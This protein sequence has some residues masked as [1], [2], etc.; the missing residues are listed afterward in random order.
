[1]QG[2]RD[3][4]VH[5]TS[6]PVPEGS[7]V[8]SGLWEPCPP[9]P[10]A[11]PPS[12]VPRPPR[13]CRH[14]QAWSG[15]PSAARERHCQ[16]GRRGGG[17]AATPEPLAPLSAAQLPQQGRQQG[18]IPP[19]LHLESLD[20]TCRAPPSPPFPTEDAV[21]SPPARVLLHAGCST[22]LWSGSFPSRGRRRNVFV[23][24]SFSSKAL[25]KQRLP[26]ERCF[27][28]CLGSWVWLLRT[29]PSAFCL[30]GSFPCT[31]LPPDSPAVLVSFWSFLRGSRASIQAYPSRFMHPVLANWLQQSWQW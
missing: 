9:S 13:P 29:F 31:P 24:P 22:L 8:C 28:A 7:G 27:A 16:S 15:A 5:T 4:R 17:Q 14:S 2:S 26:S 12:P 18:R 1:M 21:T 20:P 25:F 3:A 11:C 23:L 30:C 10:V 19:S 6:P